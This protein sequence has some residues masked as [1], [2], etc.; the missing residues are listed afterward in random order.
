[1]TARLALLT[2]LPFILSA[3]DIGAEPPAPA[4]D[5]DGPVIVLKYPKISEDRDLIRIDATAS[6]A[7]DLAFDFDDFPVNSYSVE[8][9]VAFFAARP[10]EH[11]VGI[12]AASVIDGKAK[13]ERA[14]AVLSVKGG[15]VPPPIPPPV[16]PGTPP[17]T[18][19]TTPESLA[20]SVKHYVKL[21]TTDPDRAATAGALAITYRTWSVKGGG[22]KNAQEFVKG[23]NLVTGMVLRQLGKEDE[24]RPFF[25]ALDMKLMGMG[26]TTVP[27]HQAAWKDIATGLEASQ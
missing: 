23:S 26:M 22:V 9:R 11:R 3:G 1:L 25:G 8:G 24:W 15:T 27:Q 13:Q 5:L 4:A 20:T 16:D 18:P 19:P 6:V 14:F 21:V 2:I 12:R 10:G 17:T 7:D